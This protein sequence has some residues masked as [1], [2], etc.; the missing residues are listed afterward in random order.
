MAKQRASSGL[1]RQAVAA[2]KNAIGYLSLGYVDHTV[3]A[4]KI[5]GVTPDVENAKSGAYRAV[6]PFLMVTKGAPAGLTKEFLE[7]VL[8]AEGQKIVAKEYLPVK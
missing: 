8:S 3:K 4:L 5:S 2:D 6:R 1:V 7:C